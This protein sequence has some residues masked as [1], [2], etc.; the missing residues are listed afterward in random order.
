MNSIWADLGE[1]ILDDEDCTLLLLLVG[2]LIG[3]GFLVIIFWQISILLAATVLSIY[4][5]YRV[6]RAGWQRQK[7]EKSYT[8][9]PKRDSRTYIDPNG[10]RRYSDS[11]RLVHRHIAE[12]YVVRRKL[13]DDEVV[14]HVNGNKLDNRAKNLRVMTWKEH[15]DLHGS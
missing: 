14:H 8:E 12:I 2:A 5:A 13:K 7:H 15:R 4:C 3:I 9:I 6:I 1:A 10:Y 11:D